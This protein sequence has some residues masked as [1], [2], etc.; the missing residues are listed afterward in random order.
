MVHNPMVVRKLFPETQMAADRI[1]TPPI[2]L[3]G[4]GGG[5]RYNQL[6]PID[7]TQESDFQNL[8][9]PAASQNNK[10]VKAISSGNSS[11]NNPNSRVF[12]ARTD[13]IG[14]KRAVKTFALQKENYFIDYS[15]PSTTAEIRV[16]NFEV[17]LNTGIDFFQKL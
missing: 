2:T 4:G 3:G 6:P 12:S 17:L 1:M 11:K 5:Y 16:C 13:E 14:V 7:P 10:T 9:L 15:R 8:P